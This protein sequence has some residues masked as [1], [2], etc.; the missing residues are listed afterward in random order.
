MATASGIASQH[1]VAAPTL[2][3][4]MVI[5]N[6][7]ERSVISSITTQKFSGEIKN[8]GDN[9]IFRTDPVITNFDYQI[10]GGVPDFPQADPG[11]IVLSID[12]ARSWG[13]PLNAVQTQQ[14]DISWGPRIQNAAALSIDVTLSTLLLAYMAT[15]V[16]LTNQGIAGGAIS[17]RVN[18][19]S[20]AVPVGLTQTGT[21]SA[22]K[23]V[24]Q[25][26][27]VLRETLTPTDQGMWFIVVPPDIRTNLLLGPLSNANYSGDPKSM[28]RNGQIGIIDNFVVLESTLCPAST[29]TVDGSPVTAYQCLFGWA[30]AT[31]FAQT[32]QTVEQY[33]NQKDFGDIIRGLTVWGRKVIRPSAIGLLYAYAADDAA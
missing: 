16:P 21:A 26:G 17:T 28:L 23:K 32:I 9:L 13:A 14:A 10:G 8:Y 31:A 6:F 18:L 33:K 15:Q 1:G 22:T 24:V 25:C 2:F 5:E 11:A 7:Y 29:V 12:R 30:E 19:G 4:K 20:A 27:Q 3:S